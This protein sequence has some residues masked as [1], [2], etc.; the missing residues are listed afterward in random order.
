MS[1]RQYYGEK[2][3]KAVNDQV[4]REFHASYVY[5]AMAFH[6]KRP[7]VA[8]P[9]ISKWLDD[10][11]DEEIKHGKMFMKYQAERG[12]THQYPDIKAPQKTNW[13]SI[14]EVLEDALQMEKSINENIHDLYKIAA[15]E[16]DHETEDFLVNNFFTEQT[17]SISEIARMLTKARRSGSGLG[18][19]LF[20]HHLLNK[21]DKDSKADSNNSSNE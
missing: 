8:L 15:A 2:T 5:R 4:N 3:E 10:Q 12:G 6:F 17:E 16:D 9:G 19:E 1:V 7:D 21:D 14:V 20:D 11:A 13:K 18:E